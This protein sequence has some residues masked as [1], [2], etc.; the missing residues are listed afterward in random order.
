M[1]K[2]KPMIAQDGLS[3]GNLK[4]ALNALNRPA[5][6]GEHFQ[7]GLTSSNLQAALASKPAPAPAPTPSTTGNAGGTGNA[8]SASKPG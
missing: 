6:S 4:S 1:T 8:P 5:S 7:K 2:P 3:S